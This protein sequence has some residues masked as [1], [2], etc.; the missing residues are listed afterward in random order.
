LESVLISFD[1]DGTLEAGDPPGPLSL[2]LVR[3][4]RQRGHLVGSASDRTLREQHEMWERHGFE[5]DFVTHKHHLEALRSRFE[6]SR[7]IHIG[8]RAADRHY[9][10]LAGFRF[11]F[12]MDVPA[13]EPEAFILGGEPQ[14]APTP[15]AGTP[16]GAPE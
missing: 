4:L 6:C 2:D 14:D 15:Q 13:S 5:P 16:N 7:F 3:S 12:V 11:W 10:L 8:D 9:A 1:I